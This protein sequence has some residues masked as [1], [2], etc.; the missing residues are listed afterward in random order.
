MP[1]QAFSV[2]NERELVEF[3]GAEPL[4][5]SV[6]DGYWCYEVVDGRG[7]RLRF[8]FNIFEQSV[9]TAL[10]VADSSVAVVAHEGARTMTIED[11]S[12]TCRFSY[13]GGTTTLVVQVAGAIS[14]DWASLRAGS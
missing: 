12:L 9:Q 2:P 4:D 14:M 8:S 5:R 10:Q 6:D 7:V 11:G 3:F 1:D 13:E